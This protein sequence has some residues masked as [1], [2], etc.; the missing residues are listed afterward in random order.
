MLGIC[1]G[2]LADGDLNEHEVRFLDL[3]LEDISDIANVWP[4]DVIAM[5]VRD[6]LA[7]NVVTHEELKHLK[8]ILTELIGGRLQETGATSGY[9]TKLPVNDE[10]A[11]AFNFKDD[12]F[13]FT[14]NFLF[15]TR[16]SCE[17]AI[18]NRGALAVANV[19]QDLGYL[20]IGT[21]VSSE[22]AN[23]SPGRKIEKAVDYQNSG[24]PI[25]IISEEHWVKYL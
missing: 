16:A 2:I 21:M 5:R 10:E 4:G 13:C 18:T 20:V 1:A 17:R 15:G 24:C 19:R 3:W 25:L 12:S 9:S 14:G 22:W 23:T 11:S 8:E 6:V 7:D